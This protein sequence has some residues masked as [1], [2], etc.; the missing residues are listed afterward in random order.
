MTNREMALEQALMDLSCAACAFAYHQ[1]TL[2]E[3]ALNEAMR[4]A[5][6][7]LLRS[8]EDENTLEHTSRHEH[9]SDERSVGFAN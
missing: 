9:R 5:D 7:L 8:T 1:D 6:E 2:S 3:A 4:E